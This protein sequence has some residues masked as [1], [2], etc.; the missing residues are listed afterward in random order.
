M[1]AYLLALLS[2]FSFALGT[3]LQQRGTLQ[4]TAEE[5]DPRFLGGDHPQAG[6]AAGRL[7]TGLRLG[8]PG[9]RFG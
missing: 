2:A 9:S 4:T 8:V 5:G 6:L 3:V 1:S 7:S